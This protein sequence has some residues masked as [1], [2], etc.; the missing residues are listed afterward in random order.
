M[1]CSKMKMRLITV[2]QFITAEQALP[3]SFQKF[4]GKYAFKCKTSLIKTPVITYHI[5]SFLH[6]IIFVDYA[7]IYDIQEKSKALL[8]AI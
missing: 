5:V 2:A 4:N 1:F 8:C 6:K 7:Y 3:I